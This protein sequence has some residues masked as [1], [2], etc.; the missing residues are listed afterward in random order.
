LSSVDP[1]VEVTELLDREKDRIVRL[2]SKR[3]RAESYDVV[4]P[5][6]DL[7][8]PL[9]RIIDHL[10]RLLDERGEE[11]LRLWPEWVRA[12]GAKRYDQRFD[13]DDLAREFKALHVVLLRVYARQ[14]GGRV[15]P[16]VAEF[17]AELIGE[18]TAST[19]ASYVRVVR[20]EEVRFREAAVMESV[21]HQV[22]VGIMV[23]ELDGTL[24][25][26]TPPVARLIGVPVRTLVGGR[27]SQV[28][29]PILAQL[30]ARHP[31]GEP[32]RMSDMPLLRSIR[33]KAPVRSVSMLIDRPD[34][35]EIMLELSATP[36]WEEGVEGE[37][38]GV[39]QTISDRTENAQKTQ[40]L[41]G[42]YEEL[43][44]LQGRLLQRTRTQALGQLAS[45]AAH[46]LNNF[47]NV[48]RLRITLMR[49]G[50]KV[51]HLDALDR[52]VRNIGDLV[53]RLQEFSVA[54]TEE[55][56]SDASFDQVVR[57]ALELARSEVERPG[58]NITLATRLEAAESF[59]KVDPG[60]F[61]ELIVNLMLAARD[62]MP[63]GGQ[64]AV[65]SSQADGWCTLRIQ[66]TGQPY[67]EED[68]VRLFDPL[69]GNGKAPQLSLLLAVA[70]NQVQRWGGEL[71]C[72][73]CSG[74]TAGAA[75]LL[76]LPRVV[77]AAA[78]APVE[79]NAVKPQAAPARRLHASRRVLVV[80]AKPESAQLLSQNLRDEGYE[81]GVAHSGPMALE[82]WG[83]G[84]Y[85]AALLDASLLPEMDGW[86][87]ARELRA[88]TPDARL[89]IV[90][91]M[92]VRGQ[93]RA[94]LALVDAVFRKPIDLGALDDFLSRSEEE[95]PQQEPHHV[96]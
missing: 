34:G 21:L 2:W 83:P 30:H 76:R 28:L 27:V 85:D 40:E 89:A 73:N 71:E 56:L 51:E 90:T 93:S 11:A 91:G 87:V 17:L 38:V 48:L 61:R 60:F 78:G 53:G 43:R 29:Q 52:V 22:D 1:I 96:H 86:E 82:M 44:R 33:E 47:L 6:R 74:E 81:V 5:G 36:I 64:L 7:R 65:Q 9:G 18:A 42:A 59:V 94:K 80:D 8:E 12:H 41:M 37:I 50:F 77:V 95:E 14:H 55:E 75:F 58:S 3:V 13:P 54:R 72:L 88:R 67:A 46:A 16:E 57:E 26:A 70:R 62:R 10:H 39:I 35:R 92:D 66:D 20:T 63:Q 32:F 4:I 31:T 15:E 69:K 79:Q 23:A 84:R 68:L 49:K 24:S 45:G 25:F 19:Q